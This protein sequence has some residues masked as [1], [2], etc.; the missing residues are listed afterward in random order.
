MDNNILHGRSPIL[1]I[2]GRFNL[3]WMPE[4]SIKSHYVVYR[5]IHLEI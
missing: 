3:R 1:F 4:S 5:K 2:L